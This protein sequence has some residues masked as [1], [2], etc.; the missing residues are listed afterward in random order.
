MSHSAIGSNDWA[1]SALIRIEQ[2]RV[3]T[4]HWTGNSVVRCP[5]TTS[6][7]IHWPVVEVNLQGI[8]AA[9]LPFTTQAR[10]DLDGYKAGAAPGRVSVSYFVQGEHDFDLHGEVIRAWRVH[11]PGSDWTY[12]VRKEPPYL[13]RVSHPSPD[14]KRLVSVLAGFKVTDVRGQAVTPANVAAMAAGAR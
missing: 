7:S 5:T 4:G 8:L 11:E 12:W 6:P 13:V 1:A 3:S 9:A 10:I 14:G 2:S